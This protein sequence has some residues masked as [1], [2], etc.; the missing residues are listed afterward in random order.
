[1]YFSFALTITFFSSCLPSHL[2]SRSRAEATHTTLQS[3]VEVITYAMVRDESDQLLAGG[4]A[5]GSVTEKSRGFTTAPLAGTM[6]GMAANGVKQMIA[7]EQKKYTTAYSF[8]LNNL[9]FYNALSTHGPFDPVGMQFTGFTVTRTF[10]NNGRNDT[11]LTATFEPDLSH[12]QSLIRDGFFAMRLTN[13]HVA[14]AKA[15]LPVGGKPRLNLDFD[16]S[17]L[18]SYLTREG[19]LR[20]GQVLGTFVT[21]LRDV[22]IGGTPKEYEAFRNTPIAGRSF[23][24]PRSYSYIVAADDSATPVWSRGAYSILVNVRESTKNVFVDR[25]VVDNSGLLID[26]ASKG[27]KVKTPEW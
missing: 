6:I 2:G 3:P 7:R 1:V 23:I 13:L 18:A 4:K 27:V 22:P 19:E 11:A 25:A 24:V 15:K 26:A 12:P 17:I 14:Y 10:Q 21:T 16:I 20:R 5:R 9:Y 8:A